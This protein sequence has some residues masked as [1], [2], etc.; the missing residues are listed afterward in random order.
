M[1]PLIN[2]YGFCFLFA[3][4]LKMKWQWIKAIFPC[5]PN[6]SLLFSNSKPLQGPAWNYLHH[7]FFLIHFFKKALF[8]PSFV[9]NLCIDLLTTLLVFFLNV[10][11]KKNAR[12]RSCEETCY[13]TNDNLYIARYHNDQH[14]DN[15]TWK[16]DKMAIKLVFKIN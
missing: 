2:I 16:T 6:L 11:L 1:Q 7:F 15:F 5:P 8:F 14:K 9:S 10:N 4:G 13:Q 3:V 12:R